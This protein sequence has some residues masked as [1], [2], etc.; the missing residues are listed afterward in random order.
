MQAYFDYM[1]S[2]GNEAYALKAGQK[3]DAS[4]YLG[5]A[6]KYEGD[7]MGHCVGGYCPDVL[8]GHSRIFSLRDAKG[9]PHV[10]VETKPTGFVSLTTF[11]MQ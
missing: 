2:G 9:E 10:T 6:L 8:E 5:D 11:A 4:K 1:K 7:T 3:A